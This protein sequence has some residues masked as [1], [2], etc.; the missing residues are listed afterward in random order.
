MKNNSTLEWKRCF[1]QDFKKGKEDLC[2]VSLVNSII[3]QM[4]I[5]IPSLRPSLKKLKNLCLC[6]SSKIKQINII[7]F[8]KFEK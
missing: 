5:N 2:S 1:F 6:H 8:F 4:L 7:F 3:R